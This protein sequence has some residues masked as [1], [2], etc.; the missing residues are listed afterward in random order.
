[1]AISMARSGGIGLSTKSSLYK[2]KLESEKV[3][4]SESDM[5]LDPVGNSWT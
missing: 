4:K 1:M 2:Q 5:I 3:K